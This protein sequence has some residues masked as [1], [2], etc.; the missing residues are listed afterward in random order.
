MTFT[1]QLFSILFFS[2][3]IIPVW[4]LSFLD[5]EYANQ[6]TIGYGLILTVVLFQFLKAKYNFKNWSYFL[7]ASVG[8]FIYLSAFLII[9]YPM[10][11]V[12]IISSPILLGFSLVL[13][14]LFLDFKKI[15]LYF[16]YLGIILIY[17]LLI[18]PNYHE[19]V[20]LNQIQFSELI[21]KKTQIDSLDLSEFP[22][23]EKEILTKYIAGLHEFILIE[24]WN[25]K[26]KPCISSMS[27]LQD[28]MKTK[29]NVLHIFL[30]QKMGNKNLSD[31]KVRIFKAIDQP[32]SIVI[33]VDNDF[34][35]RMQLSGYPYFILFDGQGE[36]LDWFSGYLPYFQ[37]QYQK[38][39]DR[40]LDGT[41]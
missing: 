29:E 38:Y 2:L 12:H 22:S 4:G 32:N 15:I 7:I 21:K 39:L 37:N 23:L 6:L 14:N 8:P 27:D 30:Y 26:C 35:N 24:T 5:S 25:E 19:A 11:F 28:Y 33:D 31:D 40:M 17:S 34:Y 41:I 18:Y 13:L 36:Q 20:E 9:Q 10:G 3:S 1:K 16:G